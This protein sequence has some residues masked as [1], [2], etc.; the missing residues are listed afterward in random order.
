MCILSD[1]WEDRALEMYLETLGKLEDI[2][3]SRKF[4]SVYIMGNFNA[5]PFI[6]RVWTHL[7]DF[8]EYNDLTCFDAN[9]LDSQFFTF[10]SFNNS[11]TKWGEIHRIF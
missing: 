4:G 7:T 10:V 3:S 1:I 11:S 5:D 2:L 8:M 9:M 6:G